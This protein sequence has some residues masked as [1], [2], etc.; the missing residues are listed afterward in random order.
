MLA[1]QCS[2][3]VQSE[4]ALSQQVEIAISGEWR[5]DGQEVGES[6]SAVR[7]HD[8][9]VI[10]G[11][12]QVERVLDSLPLVL[13]VGRRHRWRGESAKTRNRHFKAGRGSSAARVSA[14]TWARSR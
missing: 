1:A 8:V 2:V 7:L 5:E 14:T 13:S 10:V 11:Q 12:L 6:A 3:R 9:L 4:L